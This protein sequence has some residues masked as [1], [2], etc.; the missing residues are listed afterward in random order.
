MKDKANLTV[1]LPRRPPSPS[2]HHG[3]SHRSLQSSGRT[4]S[5]SSFMTKQNHHLYRV[6]GRLSGKGTSCS[7]AITASHLLKFC[8]NRKNCDLTEVGGCFPSRY[9][10]NRVLDRYYVV[11][12]VSMER[13]VGHPQVSSVSSGLTGTHHLRQN[14]PHKL[15]I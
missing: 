13:D 15:V 14:T 6:L 1:P 12:M 11:G 5:D 9:W 8:R 2:Y 7:W 4:P 10:D 3:S